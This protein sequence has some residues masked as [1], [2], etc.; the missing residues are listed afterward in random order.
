[1]AV[2]KHNDVVFRFLRP[3]VAC[4]DD[5][6][7]H[8]TVDHP[9]ESTRLWFDAINVRLQALQLIQVAVVIH[10]TGGIHTPSNSFYISPATR[11]WVFYSF[12]TNGGGIVFFCNESKT[13]CVRSPTCN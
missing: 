5:A 13:N 8:V 3:P 11:R 6:I 12:C 1:M 7:V 9:D 10:L 2:K 4:T